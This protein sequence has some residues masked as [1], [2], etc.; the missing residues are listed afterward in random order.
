MR[1]SAFVGEE[2]PVA[3][4]GWRDQLLFGPIILDVEPR[5]VRKWA[6][7]SDAVGIAVIKIKGISNLDLLQENLAEKPW[8]RVFLLVT[9]DPEQPD[10]YQL[11]V[12]SQCLEAEV[13][14]TAL[15][16]KL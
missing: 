1:P 8:R 14:P 3:I 16:A 4:A 13:D 2:I 7:H 6:E 15:V 11:C 10:G 9:D 12:G 5:G